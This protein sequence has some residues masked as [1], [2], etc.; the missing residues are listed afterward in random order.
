MFYHSGSAPTSMNSMICTPARKMPSGP[1]GKKY[2]SFPAAS[3]TISWNISENTDS[4]S[5]R[6]GVSTR[7]KNLEDLWSEI[8]NPQNTN[9]IAGISSPKRPIMIFEPANYPIYF[10]SLL[11]ANFKQIL[12]ISVLICFWLL[13][14]LL[15]HM[16]PHPLFWAQ[17]RS[18]V[19]GCN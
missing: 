10:I 17:F 5:E 2:Q 7:D 14:Y 16:N 9:T 11:W 12:I 6:D 3:R 8:W 13:Y 19:S 18:L 15:C 4:T 1:S